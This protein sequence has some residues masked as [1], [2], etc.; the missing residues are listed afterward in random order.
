MSIIPLFQSLKGDAELQDLT[1][2]QKEELIDNI[3][4]LDEKGSEL[5]F[6]LIKLF[7]ME[8][9][10]EASDGLPFECKFIAK[11]YR[12]DLEKLPA[13]LKQILSKFAHMHVKNM[14]EETQISSKRKTLNV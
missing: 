4:V 3:K 7:E 2:E 9:N 1:L 6:V 14:D 8:S 13:K 5:F 11:E 10:P 12:F